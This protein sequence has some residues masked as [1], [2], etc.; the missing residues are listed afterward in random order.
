VKEHFGCPVQATTNTF[1]GKWK[2]L[3]VW[4][5]SLRPHRF[6]EL[7]GLLPGVSEKVLTSQLKELARDGIVRR[8]DD[9]E[10]PRRVYYS[11]TDAGEQL[12]PIMNAMCQW[13][14]KHLG[15]RPTV[16]PRVISA[17]A[18]TAMKDASDDLGAIAG[19]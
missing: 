13:G 7:R 12:I 17:S 19:A 16:P 8:D 1:A 4:Y 10:I 5:L 18:A 3:L 15:V 9:K 14:S 2:V 11:L 6:S